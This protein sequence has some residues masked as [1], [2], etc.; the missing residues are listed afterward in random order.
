MFPLK[1][2]NRCDTNDCIVTRLYSLF[3]FLMQIYMEMVLTLHSY[4][5]GKLSEMTRLIMKHIISKVERGSN[6]L[7]TMY[8]QHPKVCPPACVSST[9][10]PWQEISAASTHGGNTSFAFIEPWKAGTGTIT[11]RRAWNMSQ[12]SKI[13]P[14]KMIDGYKV[15]VNKHFA[16]LG[17]HIY[18]FY[19]FTQLHCYSKNRYFSERGPLSYPEWWKR[20]CYGWNEQNVPCVQWSKK[21]K[22]KIVISSTIHCWKNSFPSIHS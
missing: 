6:Y 14:Q 11:L 18:L 9:S 1:H 12:W 17:L 20:I 10:C 8:L 19:I 7:Q 15:Q 16:C 5:N 13:S 4:I 22:N 21:K 3:G 2:N